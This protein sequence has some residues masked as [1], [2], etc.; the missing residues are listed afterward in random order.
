[1]MSVF[2]TMD[3]EQWSSL[4][5]KDPQAFEAQRC[6]LIDDFLTRIP[7]AQQ[8]ERLRRLQ[9]RIDQVRDRSNNPMAACLSLYTMMWDRL[10]GEGGMLEALQGMEAGAPQPL[11]NAEILQFPGGPR[12]YRG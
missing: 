11:P 6:R 7:S 8:Q 10:L 3:F 5:V 4:A 1:M 12:Q 2:A 9:W